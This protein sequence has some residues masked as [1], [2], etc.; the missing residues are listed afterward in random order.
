MQGK[1]PHQ[2][3]DQLQSPMDQL[4]RCYHSFLFCHYAFQ[5]VQQLWP[6]YAFIII[7]S[8][9][10]KNTNTKKSTHECWL[11]ATAWHRYKEIKMVAT[12]QKCATTGDWI[13]NDVCATL[14]KHELFSFTAFEPNKAFERFLHGNFQHLMLLPDNL[15]K[16]FPA[17]YFSFFFLISKLSTFHAGNLLNPQLLILRV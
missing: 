16:S 10:K 2:V 15:S 14:Y 12:R 1:Q 4:S 5:L 9:G 11:R 17:K 8:R 7:I 6:V 13:L 3:A